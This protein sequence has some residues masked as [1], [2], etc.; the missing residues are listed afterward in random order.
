MFFWYCTSP[1]HF[2]FL[3]QLFVCRALAREKYTHSELHKMY[4]LVRCVT[5]P[6]GKPL[7][8]T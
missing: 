8:Y 7:F 5:S 3:G 1:A 2:Y 6:L 4:W